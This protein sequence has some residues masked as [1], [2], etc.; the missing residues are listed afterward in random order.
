MDSVSGSGVRYQLANA[1]VNLFNPFV[2]TKPILSRDD[3]R[4]AYLCFCVF[5]QVPYEII[6]AF[7]YPVR[8]SLA[9]NVLD[10]YMDVD[11]L[12]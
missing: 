8:V 1:F 6:I 5:E 12:S 3:E 7:G 9:E 2:N 4:E 11:A 10:P